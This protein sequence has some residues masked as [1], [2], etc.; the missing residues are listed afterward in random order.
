MNPIVDKLLAVGEALLPL[1][2]SPATVAAGRKVIDLFQEA[3]DT[4]AATPEE[5]AKLEQGRVAWE[6]RILQ[7]ADSTADRLA[8]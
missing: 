8:D 1:V 2:V 6:Q 3:K 4:I 5:V 7:Y